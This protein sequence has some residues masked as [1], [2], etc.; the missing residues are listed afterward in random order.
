MN[1]YAIY[2]RKSR[3]DVEAEA[4]GEG[5][6]LAKHRKA[7][8]EYARQRG[9]LVVREYAEI[10][11]G[12]SISA[13]PQMQA[14]LE[15]VKR[16]V[17]A[18]VIVNDVDRLGRGD[19]I[20]QEII[21]ITFA[22][23]HCLIITPAKDIDLANTTDEDLYDFKAF[24]GRFE[25]K[26]ISRRMQQGRTRSA[27]SGNWVSGNP[28][29]GYRIAKSDGMIRL[30]PDPETAP[31]VKMVFD[32]YAS[33]DAGYQMISRRLDKMGIQS[34]RNKGFSPHV[35]HRMLENPAYIGRTEYGQHATVERIENGQR[36]KK[37]IKSTP[38]IVVENTHPAI[39]TPEIWQA[40]RE[41]A[42]LAR[43]RSP[44]NTNKVSANPLAGLVICAECGSV[45]QM[46]RSSKRMVSCLNTN[47]PTRSISIETLEGVVLETLRSWC[48]NYEAP[49][50]K[51]DD[52]SDEIAA[53]RRQLDGIDT[54]ITRAQE[55]VEM[56]VYS[57]A[58]Y[59]TRKEALQGR[60]DALKMQI[61][62]FSHKSPDEAKRAILPDVERVIGAYPYADTAEQKNNLLKSIIHHITYHK[63][64]RAWRGQNPAQYLRLDVFPLIRDSI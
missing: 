55:L 64:Q 3:A 37:Y 16:G 15:D 54:Q 17:Y 53:L 24:F 41:R 5:E 18:G 31:I 58:E 60:K 51:L 13:R 2:L 42:E 61:E 62:S 34:S 33:G 45:M 28:P 49:E 21:K 1:Q 23:A 27:A 47:C 22:A 6:T 9:F 4:R 30:E 57:P 8:N 40:V 50:T 44:I 43:H 10:V 63:T 29:Y 19:S 26:T 12:D 39:I 36:V 59:L 38:G 56:G 35:I 48:A 20:D 7:L 32:W 25:Y 11:S 46:T 14:L 52:K